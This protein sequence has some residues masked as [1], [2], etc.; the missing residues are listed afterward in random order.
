[1]LSIILFI[2]HILSV[3]VLI[4]L[5]LIQTNQSG[6]AIPSFGASQTLFGSQGSTPFIKKLTYFV[7]ALF[8]A[9]SLGLNTRSPYQGTVQ[10]VAP[11]LVQ[12]DSDNA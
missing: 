11:L 5:I 3:S 8:F 10:A 7:G 2:S 12:P 4:G 9:T 6:G 1:M